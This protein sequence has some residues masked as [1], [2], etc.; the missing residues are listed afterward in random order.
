MPT[1][2]S[3][4]DPDAGAPGGEPL[5]ATKLYIPS[6]R[7]NLVAR[8]GLIDRL[9]DGLRLRR[10][11]T[12]VC[13]PAGFGKTTL[14]VEWFHSSKTRQPAT[15]VGWL[16]LEKDDDD[17]ARF[18][19]YLTAALRQAGAT[20]GPHHHTIAALARPGRLDAA[21]AP[22][23]NEIASLPQLV[24]LA[25]DDY[26]TIEQEAIHS[27]I[28]Y[29]L[30]HLPPNLHL[31][32]S[33]RA[34]PPLSL[35][36]LR[37]RGQLTE[38]RQADL[39]FTPQEAAAF[40]NR[41]IG[42]ALSDQ[43]VGRLERRTEGWIAGL[44]LAA[45]SMQGRSD[46][47]AFIHAFSGSHHY[48]LDYLAEEV[49]Q[50]QPAGVQDFLRQTSVLD[51]L[52]APLCDA[53]LEIGETAGRDRA[54]PSQSTL[55]QLEAA[56][57]FVVPLD[58]D[59]RWYRY[60]Q[61][62]AEFLRRQLDQAQPGLAPVLHRRASIWYEQNGL[63]AEAIGHALAARDLERAA[64]LV[65]AAA[66]AT[67]MRSE[68]ATYRAWVDALPE[69]IVRRRPTLSL[70][71]AWA[72]LVAARPVDEV[73][74]RLR[75]A[76]QDGVE[77]S[78]QAAVL[79]GF[80]AAFQGQAG[81]GAD[82]PR[83][84]FEAASP[85]DPFLRGLAAWYLGF[86][87]MWHDDLDGAGLAFDQAIQINREAGNVMIATM[88]MCHR[89]EVI[90]MQGKLR[91]AAS[92]YEQA[93]ALAVDGQ[94]APLPIAGMALI[95]LAE[96]VREQNDLDRAQRLLD[97]G[98]ERTGQW[99]EMGALDAYITLARLRQ[100]QNDEAGLAEAIAAAVQYAQHFDASDMDDR[101]VE[102]QQT[103]SW[104]MRGR[105]AEA[106]QWAGRRGQAL[107][108]AAAQDS[109]VPRT[110]RYMEWLVLARL[111]TSQGRPRDGLAILQRLLPQMERDGRWG[112]AIEVHILAALALQAAGD[113]AQALLE[114]EQALSLAAPEG[115]VR[116]FADEGPPL[117]DLLRQ[118]A[119]RGAEPE[120]VGRLLAT[121]RAGEPAPTPD[122]GLVEPLA[123]REIE[124]LR[125]IAAGLS[126][127]EI[128]EELIVAVS[129]V[130]WHINNL[131]GKLGVSSRTQAV[132]RARELHLL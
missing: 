103:R 47:E 89:A 114:L 69:E 95:G 131:Y 38:L 20:I 70:Y 99:G 4:I 49:L 27:A 59:R 113:T 130:K 29:L 104:V 110:L 11:L 122:A 132:A 61:L 84:L 44:Q 63:M 30:D 5:L 57:L 60:H 41:T 87:C 17:P 50:R 19:A 125:L 94:G 39:R 102:V 25:L 124:V 54:I 98:L 92:L 96:V 55:E 62:F 16:S 15:S 35:S 121:I 120:Y 6:A 116:I 9:D 13:A 77:T 8:H 93:M 78:G 75:D 26:H 123:G 101:F 128:A 112:S 65:E 115:Y 119:A 43:D 85:G 23:I 14:L 71:Y 42:L 83:R 72:L 68:F 48:V 108:S 80:L 97:E 107:E 45:L 3:K 12:L 36:R 53:M 111:M 73:L 64:D 126:N 10:K 67:L 82:L 33:G 22:L 28:S 2:S 46:L 105:L 81:Q 51:R 66:K 109:P 91:A 76:D 24:L 90:M 88:A 129:T 74:A 117:G 100:A 56:N 1:D 32:I 127:Q 40:L 106:E 118:A 18:L 86:S 7:P 52:S 79:R 34:D 58:G 31:V 37:A 21:L